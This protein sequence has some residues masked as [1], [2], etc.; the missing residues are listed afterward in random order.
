MQGNTFGKKTERQREARYSRNYTETGNI[1]CNSNENTKVRHRV[2]IITA[3]N[4]GPKQ[5]QSI[6]RSTVLTCDGRADL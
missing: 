1:E 6:N 4:I 5:K 3:A 2:L